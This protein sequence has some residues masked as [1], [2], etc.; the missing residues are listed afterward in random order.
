MRQGRA[1][2]TMGQLGSAAKQ[3]PGNGL[4]RFEYGR[5]LYQVGRMAEAEAE[6]SASRS[7]AAGALLV[8]VRRQRAAEAR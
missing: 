3:F 6:L 7:E 2:E 4:V 8:K 1:A 5:A